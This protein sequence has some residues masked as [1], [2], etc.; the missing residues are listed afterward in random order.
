MAHGSELIAGERF[1]LVQVEPLDN[2][3]ETEMSSIWNLNDVPAPKLYN[4]ESEFAWVEEMWYDAFMT[5]TSQNEN[6]N[7]VAS[8]TQPASQDSEWGENNEVFEDAIGEMEEM[9]QQRNEDKSAMDLNKVASSQLAEFPSPFLSVCHQSTDPDL[10]MNDLASVPNPETKPTFDVSNSSTGAIR[11]ESMQ[12]ELGESAQPN[13]STCSEEN[14]GE[15]EKKRKSKVLVTPK[16]TDYFKKLSSGK[17][18][19]KEE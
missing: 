11:S 17:K 1:E 9:E 4:D 5:M 14:V 7:E 15:P 18:E 8:V 10:E 13:H 19:N 16:I 12:A 6:G 2:M 3:M